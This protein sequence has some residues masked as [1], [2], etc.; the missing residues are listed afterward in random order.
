MNPESDAL[1]GVDVAI[2]GGGAAGVL[3]AIRL[4]ADSVSRLRIAI[5]EPAAEL[6]R[7]AAYATT[8]AEHLLNVPVAGMS[9]LV[10]DPQHFLRYLSA[11]AAVGDDAGLASTF[12]ARRDY[13][14]YLRDTLQ[15]QPRHPSLHWLRD[16]VRDIER[17]ESGNA[18]ILA[19]GRT[20]AARA[21]VLAVG[22]MPRRI[23]AS[24]LRGNPR[25]A[26]AWDYPA[27]TAIPE[28]ADVC[29]IGSGLSMVDAV[30]GLVHAGHRGRIRVLSRHGLMPLAH[31]A[32]GTG[33]TPLADLA[34]L[35]LHDRL[36]HVRTL[37]RAAIAAGEPWQWVFDRLRPHGQALWRSLDHAEQ[38]RFL[39]HVVRYWDIHRHRIA[40]QVAATLDGLRASGRLEVVA[41]RML[42]AEAQSD[43]SIEVACLP[44]H[45]NE[46]R[47]LRADWLV[48]ATGVE[49]HVDLQPDTLLGALRLRGRV[50]PGP[51]GI[52]IASEE[53]GCVFDAR[54]V[55]DPG[56]CVL[57]AMRI[58]TL[59]ESIAI[60]E[61]RVQAR[62]LAAHLQTLLAEPPVTS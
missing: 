38:R 55:A 21:V 43:G 35:R 25:L 6:A 30:L 26:E 47:R 29:I 59:W 57:G 7:G 23:P 14:R 4:L 8:Q 41:G 49:T 60:P 12:V 17:G 58:G 36:R 19:S 46:V 15:A 61:L 31:A 32:A 40:P 44:R 45:G 24:R 13:G 34:T 3:V 20:L 48:N 54:G 5:I 22:N 28:T 56:L 33:T 42:G 51:H 50:L 18:V 27:V 52:G 53:P 39:R 11:S 9:A 2:V 37:A 1:A 16:Q 62:N 10:E